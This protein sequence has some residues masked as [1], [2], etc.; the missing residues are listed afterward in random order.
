MN[1][2]RIY[3]LEDRLVDFSV[4]ILEIAKE[5]PNTAAGRN[6]EGQLVKSGTSVTLNYG[7]VQG[8]EFAIDYVPGRA[9]GT[10][11]F[12]YRDLDIGLVAKDSGRQDLGQ[13]VLS[14]LADRLGIH[15]ANPSE[16]GKA[17]RVGQVDVTYDDTW[18]FFKTLWVPLRDGLLGLVRKL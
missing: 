17:P 14:F 13:K 15:G 11:Q 10:V 8:A 2:Q 6:L 1:E 18:P 4:L 3:D 7:E 12:F 16:P 9:T 5:L